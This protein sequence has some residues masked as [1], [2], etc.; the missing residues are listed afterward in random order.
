MSDGESGKGTHAPPESEAAR[1]GSSSSS[2][3]LEEPRAYVAAVA[4]RL[5]PFWPANPKVW[6]VQVE[7]QFSRRGI[8]T[9]RTKYEEIL[10]AL[11]TEY[12]TE[13]Q[14]LLLDPPDDQP[15][16]KLK[17]L[18]LT[19]IAD[20]ER[21]KLRQLLTAEELGDRK[22]SHLLRKMKSLLGAK[23]K[24]IDSSLLRELFLQRLPSNVQMILASA[25]TTAI[26]KLADMADRIIEAAPPTIGS[27]SAPATGADLRSIIREEVAAALNQQGRS[28]PRYSSGG[29]RGGR[30][31]S[32]R[33]SASRGGTR[34]EEN[35]D[36]RCWYHQR[37]G[38]AARK[39]RPPC[40]AGN[41]Q[42]SR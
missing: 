22:P 31:R 12:A 5:P 24:V 3:A 26:D 19:R 17:E 41:A 28:H 40:T 23:A 27:V 29:S 38:D 18:L 6:F 8:T 7:A 35:H 20:S 14:D 34:S 33:R 21:Q 30:N 39:C 4:M 10:C 2:M 11:P 37:Y 9:S 25:D 36:G 42:A 15:Y 16:E 1:A 32:R 13:I